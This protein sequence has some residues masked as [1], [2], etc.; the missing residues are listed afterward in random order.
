MKSQ[1]RTRLLLLFTALIILGLLSFL[2]FFRGADTPQ[3][4]LAESVPV[5]TESLGVP[6]NPATLLEITPDNVQNVIATLER[7]ELY[8]R[9]ISQTRYWSNGTESA[10]AQAEIWVTPQA[11]RI[12]WDHGE[13]MILTEDYFYIWFEDRPHQTR[14]ITAGLGGSFDQILDEFQGIPSYEAV[15]ELDPSQIMEAGYVLKDIDGTYEYCIYLVF[16]GGTL[17]Y[18][19]RYYI[20]LSSGLLVAMRTLDGNIPIFHMETLRLS[21]DAP[22]NSA[23]TLPDGTMVL[24]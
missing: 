12:A 7:A 5:A 18:I 8:S 11:L 3:V 1:K 15:L 14:P 9:T 20:S 19:D 17:G 4:Y 21:L 13:N 23:F 24:G 10:V 22:E 6:D 2:F 16:Q